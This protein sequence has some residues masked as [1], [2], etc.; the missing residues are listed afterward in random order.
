MPSD[1]VSL[2]VRAAERE[3]DSEYM[4][5]PLV[6]RSFGEAA[7]Y[8]LAFCE[9]RLVAPTLKE[10]AG[11]RELNPHERTALADQVL[12]HAKWPLRWLRQSCP[13][14]GRIPVAYDDDVYGAA[15]ELSKL[16]LDYLT[17]ETVFTYASLGLARLDLDQQK[18]VA[19]GPF[20]DDTRYEAYDRLA[21]LD[22]HG[23]EFDLS[24]I[25]ELV[26][27]GVRVDG[28]RFSYPM[29]PRIVRDVLAAAESK[30]AE[31]LASIHHVSR[32]IA[33]GRGCIGMGYSN[34][35]IVMGHDELLRRLIRYTN[36]GEERVRA[37]VNEMTYGWGAVTSPD[38]ALQPLVP[39]TDSKIAWAP[40]LLLTNA[41]ERNLVV[42][43][44]RSPDARRAYARLSTKKEDLLRT[45][46]TQDLA[47]LG[48]RFWNG[49][50]PGWTEAPDIDFAIISDTERSCLLLELKSFIAPAEP[51]EIRDRSEEIARGIA[52][53]KAR[54][55]LAESR[56]DDLCRALGVRPDYE[57]G[58]A[59][60]S[61]TSVGAGWVQDE[62]V[63]VVRA[64]HLVQK[65][66][67][68]RLLRATC[69][70]L[71]RREHLPVEGQDYETVP[72]TVRIG[73]WSL[74]WHA[75]RGLREVRSG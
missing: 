46:L 10:A 68:A 7:W 64:S 37:I 62:A 5:N 31:V 65:L 39:L 20:R 72:V 44:N 34:A 26:H 2:D 49:D 52:Q 33:A 51:R 35:L 70:W 56:R 63:P 57:F 43:L 30:L 75:I 28:D 58:W 69:S 25:A 21:D 50:I 19:T 48:F 71:A 73:S 59:V 13:P 47:G 60:A 45:R 41:F 1:P 23:E 11:D 9:D 42:L 55:S 29:N 40:T 15:W 17:F 4:S 27:E 14:G 53:I 6:A 74:D 32:L 61:E 12:N 67:D 8:F 54:R 16:A 22:E 66:R 38:P 36:L 18:V 24:S 3:I